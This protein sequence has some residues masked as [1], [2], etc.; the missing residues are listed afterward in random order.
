MTA[1]HFQ[2]LQSSHENGDA[3]AIIQQLTELLTERNEFHKL[4]D[5]KMLAKKHSLGLPLSHPSSLK[6]VPQELRKEVEE[7]YISAARE[8]GENFL[9]Q[10]DLN[11]AWM[12][13]QV[14]NEPEPVAKALEDLADSID[15]YDRIEEILQIAL[16]Q[17]VNPAKGVK[18]ML[19]AHGTCST[20]TALDQIM[21]Q[22]TQ[23]QRQ[24]CSKL[25]V[26]SIYEDVT[27]SVRRNVENRIPML[28]PGEPLRT[29]I[30]GREWLFEGGNYHVDVSHLNSV[31]RFARS[32]EAP[33]EELDMA[34]QLAMYGSQLERTLQY[35][36][37]APFEDFYPAHIQF[38]N[39]LLDKNREEGLQYFRNKLQQEPDEQDKPLLAYVLVDL[40]V[41]SNK[42]EEA[43]EVSAQHLSNLGEEVSISFDEL[44][45]KAGKLDTL[46][47]V[48]QDQD[49]L[50]GYAAALLRE[51]K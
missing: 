5:A 30:M 20:I 34:Q 3:S 40:L 39:V 14:I 51:A 2:A 13:F 48:R 16:Y 1:D 24:A 19:N 22:M 25:M 44:C 33:A 38:F 23:E 36:G 21:H 17:G 31:V 26:R 47:Q 32:I 6:D 18:L 49:D 50:V 12:Y 46:K 43:V 15:D 4:F 28:P 29:L 35:D 10:G 45:Q 42:L 8:A 27:E 41:R 11:S 7:T 37:E 9:V